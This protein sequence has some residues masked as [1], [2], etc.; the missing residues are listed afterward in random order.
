[1]L[2]ILLL[3]VNV[4]MYIVFPRLIYKRNNYRPISKLPTVSKSFERILFNQ[5]QRFSNKI[6]SPLLC[7][8]RKGYSTQYPNK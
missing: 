6:L 4:R 5:L 7:G 8:F 3:L 2:F 1:M